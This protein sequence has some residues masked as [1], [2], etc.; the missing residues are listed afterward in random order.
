MD[1]IS[2]NQS[3]KSD[4]AEVPHVR[5][6][7]RLG[8]ET[9]VQYLERLKDLGYLFHGSPKDTITELEPRTSHDPHSKENTDTAVFA[10]NNPTWTVIFGLYDRGKTW[11]TSGIERNIIASIP[12][13]A[14]EQ[15]KHAVGTV[16]V[17]SPETFSESTHLEQ[18]KSYKPV[19]PIQ[20]ISVTLDDFYEL[21][22]KVEWI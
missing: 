14:K 10:T 22:G 15:L 2:M 6:I 1:T 4:D 16:Y 17:L 9:T 11:K 3:D 12:E 5:S 21:G 18:Y 20:K 19:K 8:N 13:E 7:E